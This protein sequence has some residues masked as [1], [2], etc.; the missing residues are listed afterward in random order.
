MN[1][2][3]WLLAVEVDGDIIAV[4]AGDIRPAPGDV[5]E[6]DGGR[7]GRV[8]FGGLYVE[9][10]DELAKALAVTNPIDAIAHYPRRLLMEEKSDADS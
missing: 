7:L 8:L 4:H 5:I 2:Y 10:E 9:G 6:V 3:V 1:K